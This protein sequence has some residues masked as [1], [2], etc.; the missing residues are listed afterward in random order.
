MAV[1]TVDSGV[2]EGE[3]APVLTIRWLEQL[4]TFRAAQ[5]P[6]TVGRTENEAAQV[7]IA[8]NRISREHI[9][10]TVRGDRWVGTVTGRNGAFMEGRRIDGEFV[11]PPDSELDVMLGHPSGGIAMSFST[12]DP[13]NVYV[14]DQIARRRRALNISQRTLADTGVINAGALIGIEKGRSQPRA[15]TETSLEQALGWPAGYIEELRRYARA[16]IFQSAPSAQSTPPGQPPQAPAAA[17]VVQPVAEEERTELLRTDTANETTTTVEVTLVTDSLHIAVE[18]IRSRMAMLPPPTQPEYP[19]EI[20]KLVTDLSRLE[21]LASSASHNSID[22]VRELGDIRRLR[23][24]LLLRAATS[25]HARLGHTLFA[26]RQNAELS[27]DEAA[28]LAKVS[29]E[30]VRLAE[31]GAQLSAEVQFALQ[32]FVT[33]MGINSGTRTAG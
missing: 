11:V 4:Q 13:V 24:D 21:A 7:H 10:L 14:G 6:L 15:K 1:A 23:R 30:D 19:G 22:V 32:R 3:R 31:A 18:A 2:R 17:A 26:V 8:D 16:G 33:A 5:A 25:P 29:A 20:D 9:T 27:L 12:R 28:S